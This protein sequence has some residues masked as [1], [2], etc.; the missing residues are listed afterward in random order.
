MG[1]WSHGPSRP[2]SEISPRTTPIYHSDTKAH[3]TTPGSQ[4]EK[5]LDAHRLY[6]TCTILVEKQANEQL[7]VP[8]AGLGWF[9]GT[10]EYF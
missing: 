2:P 3:D 8:R 7:L 1:H 10:R 9:C 4:C 5:N 6:S